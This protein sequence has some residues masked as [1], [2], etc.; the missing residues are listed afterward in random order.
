MGILSLSTGFLSEIK[1][2]N[3]AKCGIFKIYG[4]DEQGLPP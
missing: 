1:L 3:A 4:A 2:D